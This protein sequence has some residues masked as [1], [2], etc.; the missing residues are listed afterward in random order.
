MKKTFLFALCFSAGTAFAQN[1][2][3]LQPEIGAGYTNA[4]ANIPEA[5]YPQEYY[6]TKSYFTYNFQL[7]A[8]Y[9]FNN[10]T[11]S[12]GAGFL[13]SGY[14]GHY[15][16]SI[17]VI[18]TDIKTTKYGY[19]V[20]VPITIAYQFNINKRFFITPGIGGAVSYNCSEKEIIK[21][22]YWDVAEHKSITGHSFDSM[23]H[24]ISMWGIVQARVGYK[25]NNRLN[26]IAGPEVQ[27]MLTSI[28]KDK[29]GYQ[30][31]YVYTFNAGIMWNLFNE[32]KVG[33]EA[34]MTK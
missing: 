34:P 12:S 1:G 22:K 20:I 11:I 5:R 33:E 6:T 14:V 24:R 17:G 9:H 26:I 2:F 30:R 3:F 21:S 23:Y 10:W 18:Q 15:V 8:G 16:S 4:H 32:R 27:Y 13:R 19:Q 25:I 7:G 28:L 31:N 29:N